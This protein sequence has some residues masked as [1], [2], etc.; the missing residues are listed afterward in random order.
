VQ[1]YTF[2]EDFVWGVATASYQIEGAIEADGRKP[3]IWDT[4]SAT[5]GKVVKGD[6]GAVACDH[7]HRYLQDIA[8]MRDSLGVRNYR[9]SIAWPRVLP[10]GTGAVNAAGLDFYDRLVDA[11]LDAGITPWATLYHWDLPQVLEDAGGWPARSI[12][13]A[14]VEYADVVTRRLSDR[15]SNWM[16]FNEPWVFTFLGY[17]AGIHAPGRRDWGAFLKGAHHMLLAHAQALPV[18]RGN[19]SDSTQAGLVLNLSWADPATDSAED[20]AAADRQMS[21]QNR[22]F[23]DPIYNGHYPEDMRTIYEDAGIMPDV[24]ADDLKLIATGKPDFL[25]VNF[26]TREVV[27]AGGDDPRALHVIPQEGEHTAMG[28]EVSPQAIDSVVRWAHET[29]TPGPIYI[30][31]NG[32]AFPDVVAEDGAVHDDRR[33]AFYQAYLA[34][35]HKALTSGV[36]VRGY[37]AWSLLDNFEWAE[38]Y[39]K[40][41]GITYVDYPTQTRILKDSGKWYAQTVQQN[42]FQR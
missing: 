8:L 21:F 2:P 34:N 10:D 17:A 16:T 1:S 36:P 35:V 23:M 31:E 33:V 25:G 5:P 14:Y 26:Y 27:A 41:F 19:G 9:F 32:A 37:F 42:G 39:S 6:T 38:G 20:R 15:V 28:W 24:S 13:D 22:W 11:L 40:R 12:V 18:I 3:S 4:F 29:Y 7:Y 30:T